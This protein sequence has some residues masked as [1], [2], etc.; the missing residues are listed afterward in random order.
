MHS[1]NTQQDTVSKN[2][3]LHDAFFALIMLLNVFLGVK[4]I[5]CITEDYSECYSSTLNFPLQM[6]DRKKEL[7]LKV[8]G[9][10][11]TPGGAPEASAWR[12]HCQSGGREPAPPN[13]SERS[14]LDL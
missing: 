4:G 8:L 11:F 10:V 2:I 3:K 13:S 7:A 14:T 12:C 1:S 5:Y 6:T 9:P